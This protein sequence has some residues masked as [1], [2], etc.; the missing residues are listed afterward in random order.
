MKV[1]ECASDRFVEQ[2]LTPLQQS[3]RYLA[4]GV[5]T[6][7][8]NIFSVQNISR[9]AE[10]RKQ[11]AP[12]YHWNTLVNFE[13]QLD[14]LSKDFL[15]RISDLADSGEITQLN[16]W[17]HYYALDAIATIAV[18][19]PVYTIARTKQRSD[20]L[21]HPQAWQTLRPPSVR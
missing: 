4:W 15:G 3:P 1:N 5:P 10:R 20:I 2:V 11:T 6:L 14:A 8:Q 19:S 18:G 7:E 9:H 12:L 21:I 16:H 17:F 13:P